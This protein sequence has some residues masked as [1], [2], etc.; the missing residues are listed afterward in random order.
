MAGVLVEAVGVTVAGLILALLANAVSPR[1]LTLGRDYFPGV[2]ATGGAAA[3]RLPAGSSGE[4]GGANADDAVA[5]RVAALGFRFLTLADAQA[6]FDDPRRLQELVVFV[7]ARSERHFEEGHIPGAYVFDRYYPERHL[8]EVMAAAQ[9]SEM[10]VVY[11][12]G[13]DCE[14]SE[15]AAATLRDAGIPVERLGVF[16]GGITQW[17]A[18]GLP[19][20]TGQ[21][22]SGQITGGARE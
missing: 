19:V 5:V 6:L 12:T 13:G 3:G 9:A 15:F 17:A 4:A 1:G 2:T 8:P 20:E 22:G 14:D 10:V 7:D 21:R 18:A 11:C 16:G